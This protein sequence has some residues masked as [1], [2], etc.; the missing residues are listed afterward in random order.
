MWREAENM[1]II[2][3]CIL[4]EALSEMGGMPIDYKEPSMTI[5]NLM[6]GRIKIML[7]PLSAYHSCHI[8][9]L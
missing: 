1:N 6:S 9:L 8:T 4:Q 3:L 5:G 7:D 2:L